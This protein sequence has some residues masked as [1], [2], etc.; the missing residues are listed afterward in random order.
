MNSAQNVVS[1]KKIVGYLPPEEYKQVYSRAPR[2]CIELVVQLANKILI[3]RRNNEPLRGD[4]A[5]PG[6]R[7]FKGET[8]TEAVSRIAKQ[9]LGIEVKI[10]RQIEANEFFSLSP[11]RHDVT[12]AYLVS[13]VGKQTIKLDEQHSEYK[14]TDSVA[15]LDERSRKEVNL[16]LNV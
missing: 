6:G 1:R 3:C 13:P 2:L 5:L 15:L 9:E 4:W 12:V 7:V 11:D 8:L 16:A 14:W 10:D